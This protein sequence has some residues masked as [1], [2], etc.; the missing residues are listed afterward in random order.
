MAEEDDVQKLLAKRDELLAEVKALKAQKAELETQA[1]TER[2]RAEA[3]EAEVK[4]VR[5]DEPVQ[6]VLGDLFTVKLKYVLPDIEEAFAFQIGE[7]GVEFRT[8]DGEPVKITEGGKE[9]E[10]AFTPQDVR[11]AL[12]AH[13]GFDEVLRAGGVGGAGKPP[14]FGSGAAPAEPERKTDQAVAPAFG[15]R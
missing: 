1:A 10:A 6:E 14:A 3:A 7:A 5:L 9:R 12:E 2:E 13:G 8:K 4:R 11:A 15:L